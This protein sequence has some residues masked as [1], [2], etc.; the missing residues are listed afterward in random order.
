MFVRKVEDGVEKM[1]YVDSRNAINSY[2]ERRGV[3]ESSIVTGK[4][5]KSR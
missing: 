3:R 1:T 5:V 4:E 2:L